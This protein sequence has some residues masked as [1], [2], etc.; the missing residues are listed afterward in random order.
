[1]P[2]YPPLLASHAPSMETT[3]LTP[4]EEVLFKKWLT[5]SG[6]TD[7]DHP[8][9]RYDYR[10]LFKELAGRP[11]P[12]SEGRHF[13]DTYKQHGHPTFSVESR[14]SRGLRDG[15]QWLTD[16]FLVPPMERTGARDTEADMIRRALTTLMKD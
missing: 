16:D 3:R 1:M 6:I 14:Y 7:A 11:V 5:A 12:Q 15:G 8:Q 13:P 9:S 10:G 4:Q 2:T